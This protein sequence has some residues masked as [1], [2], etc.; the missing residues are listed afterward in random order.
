MC[1]C[2]R[3]CEL[4]SFPG[5]PRLPHIRY[6]IR[7]LIWHY[8]R[9][10][11]GQPPM[12]F[13]FLQSPSSSLTYHLK[14]IIRC[15]SFWHKYLVSYLTAYRKHYIHFRTVTYIYIYIL[16]VN[17]GFY[18]HP[19]VYVEHSILYFAERFTKGAHSF[20]LYI[21]HIY[22]TLSEPRLLYI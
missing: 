3:D 17:M 10:E 7:S 5:S 14:K 22:S 16:N 6:R 9:I 8:T 18:I 15:V 11:T 2:R 12:M 1:I 4:E 19:K 21:W 13:L 20:I